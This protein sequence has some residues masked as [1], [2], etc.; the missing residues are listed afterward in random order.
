MAPFDSDSD[1]DNNEFEVNENENWKPQNIG[2]WN[3]SI[4][5]VEDNLNDGGYIEGKDYWMLEDDDDVKSDYKIETILN[6]INY[7]WKQNKKWKEKRCK[8]YIIIIDRRNPE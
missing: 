3:Q 7:L 4:W 2:T 6:R 5:D 1:N 8:R